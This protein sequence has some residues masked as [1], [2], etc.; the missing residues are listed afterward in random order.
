MGERQWCTGFLALF[1]ALTWA[2]SARAWILH[3]SG[4]LI[5]GDR[6]GHETCPPAMRLH[7]ADHARVQEQA[8]SA[9]AG[10]PFLLPTS[11]AILRLGN[12]GGDRVG[13]FAVPDETM[14]RFPNWG[15]LYRAL[16]LANMGYGGSSELTERI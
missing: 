2:A 6:R 7:S 14:Q 9:Q 3:L 8:K 5:R 1:L 11:D 13:A 10:D 16:V 4:R 15:T 12:T